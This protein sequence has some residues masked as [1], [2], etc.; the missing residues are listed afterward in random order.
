MDPALAAQLQQAAALRPEVQLW[1]GTSEFGALVASVVWG[2]NLSQLYSYA[3]SGRWDPLWI[4]FLITWVVCLDTAHTG[5]VWSWLFDKTVMDAAD[6]T[7]LVNLFDMTTPLI[8]SVILS[9]FIGASVQSFYAYR[10][11]RLAGHPWFSIPAWLGC[12]ARAAFSIAIAVYGHRAR[13][14]IKFTIQSP[15]AVHAVLGASV[16]VDLLNT[17]VIVILLARQRDGLQQTAG[18]VSKMTLWTIETGVLTSAT[19]LA[20]LGLSLANKYSAVPALLHVYAKL[21]SFCLLVTL[22]ARERLRQ[23]I[24]TSPPSVVPSRSLSR[25]N[26]QFS[27]QEPPFELVGRT[28][29]S[30][31]SPDYDPECADYDSD[32]KGMPVLD[33][34]AS[35]I[36]SPADSASPVTPVDG[37]G[38][39]ALRNPAHP[40]AARM[41]PPKPG[42]I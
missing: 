8:M 10:V 2:L 21:F 36:G 30:Q 26:V 29:R 15:W 19:A 13:T 24:Y 27:H 20:M 7:R 31:K 42:M 34:T 37:R 6:P 22:N 5:M 41:R 32:V 12:A 4:R 39:P 35:P 38:A 28:F 25:G 9:G 1:L 3:T 18:M 33:L 17:A 40:F 16:G 14:L 11:S 23:A